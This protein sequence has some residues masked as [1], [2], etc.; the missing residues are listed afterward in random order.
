MP[1]A[2]RVIRVYVTDSKG[3]RIPDATVN[4][5][6]DG[7]LIA[8]ATSAID[9]YGTVYTVQISDPSVGVTLE[10]R[11]RN[12][13]A[14]TVTLAP[15]ADEWEFTFGNV[16][17]PVPREKALWE[18]HIAGIIGVVF[19]LITIVLAIV[20]PEPTPFQFRVFVGA[21]AMC[22]SGI[23][24]EIPGFMHVKLSLG[25]QLVA[26]AAGALAIF[27]L[28]YFFGPTR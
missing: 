27:L 7:E 23:A 12:E 20:F 16:E 8:T 10:A 13:P 15:E 28:V 24:A 3:T 18:E 6:I 21:L 14:Q 11:Y 9:D 22:L 17:V 26:T 19:L 25:R 5:I 2:D 1:L 4:V